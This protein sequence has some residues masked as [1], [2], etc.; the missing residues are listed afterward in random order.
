MVDLK[1]DKY[2]YK[3]IMNGSYNVKYMLISIVIP[4]YNQAQYLSRAVESLLSQSYNN[5]EAI[6][7]DN[8]SSDCT[9]EVVKSF[10]DARI[11]YLN[12]ANNGVIAASRNLGIKNAN[13]G[14]IAFLDSDDWWTADKLQVCVDFINDDVDL[15]YHKMKIYYSN[16]G[17]F[18]RK[19]VCNRQLKNPALIDLLINGNLICNSSVLVRKEMLQKI[20]YINESYP[21]VAAEDYNSWLRIAEISEKFLFITKVL[22]YYFINPQAQSKRDMSLPTRSAINNF[23]HLLDSRNFIKVED[24]LQL[25]GMR[26]SYLSGNSLKEY[27]FLLIIKFFPFIIFHLINKFFRLLF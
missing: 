26:A 6:I 27:N 13:G 10:G 21:M 9:A 8:N 7:V 22:G 11:K 18:R 12:F 5:W 17:I 20:N 24:R 16:R 23:L 14:W 19:F 25:M 3:R 1:N 15:I 4:T 2:T